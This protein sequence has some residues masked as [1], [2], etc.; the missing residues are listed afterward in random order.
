MFAAALLELLSMRKYVSP[1]VVTGRD[2]DDLHEAAVGHLVQE[3]QRLIKSCLAGIIVFAIWLSVAI[4]F[5]CGATDDY[6]DHLQLLPSRARQPVFIQLIVIVL[7]HL[8]LS[9]SFL[10]SYAGVAFPTFFILR[11]C[12]Y[13]SCPATRT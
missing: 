6:C 7:A 2:R 1:N 9:L 13:T 8:P 5:Q 10:A 11:K 4:I 3:A 12:M